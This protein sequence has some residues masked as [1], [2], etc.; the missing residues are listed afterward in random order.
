MAWTASRERFRASANN[1]DPAHS[2]AR[3][4]LDLQSIQRRDRSAMVKLSSAASVQHG[5]RLSGPFRRGSSFC[6]FEVTA[7]E[8]ALHQPMR[9]VC[10]RALSPL[11]IGDWSDCLRRLGATAPCTPGWKRLDTT[12]E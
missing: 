2:Q 1:L 3:N 6:Q 11:A 5:K 12:S 4:W 7:N 10:G 8:P 9:A